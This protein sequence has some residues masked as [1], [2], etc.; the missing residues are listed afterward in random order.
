MKPRPIRRRGP[1]RAT[2]NA[3]LIVT[4]GAKTE[5]KYF[6]A[7]RR[8]LGLRTTEVKVLR[9]DGNDAV[10]VVST[11]IQVRD[12]RRREVRRGAS[13]V[14]AFDD[15][16]AVFD[17]ERADTNPKLDEALRLAEARHIKVALSNPCFEYWVMLHYGFTTRGFV[18]CPEVV[19]WLRAKYLKDYVKGSFDHSCLLP[20]T[21]TAVANAEKCRKAHGSC[22]RK[23][24][25]STDVDI[26]ILQ[27]NAATRPKRRLL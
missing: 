17:S 12:E 15:V 5:P 16:W 2:G 22:V 4:E 23:V 26:L 13:Q 18:D 7:V 20:R 27:L 3:I 11:A 14:V 6:E 8:C 24:N 21:A 10:S 1:A 25:P 19:K 9:G